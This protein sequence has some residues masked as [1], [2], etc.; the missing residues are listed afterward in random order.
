[1]SVV[2]LVIFLVS[3]G[4]DAHGT[5]R[6][7]L[8]GD[9]VKYRLPSHLKH[10][11][12]DSFWAGLPANESQCWRDMELVQKQA[13]GL[14]MWALKMLDASAKLPSGIISGNL[15]QFGDFDEC[16]SVLGGNQGQKIKGKYCLAN[17]HIKIN[18]ENAEE[19]KIQALDDAIHSHRM[20][21]NNIFDEGHRIPKFETFVWG[22]CVPSSCSSRDIEAALGYKLKKISK[23]SPLSFQMSIND[24]MCYVKEEKQMTVAKLL[25]TKN[26]S[27]LT[28]TKSSEDDIDCLNGARFLNAIAL[29][30]S[31]KQI[32]MFY[33]PTHNRTSMA[34]AFSKSWTMLGRSAILY[35]DSFIMISGILASYS[36]VKSLDRKRT[37][38]FKDKLINRLVRF[39]PNL[40][41]TL[42]F[43]TYLMED[44]NSGPHWGLVINKYADLCKKNM[45]RNLL[46]I[47]NYFGFE[48]MC[49][50][51]THQLGIDMQLFLVSPILVYILWKSPRFGTVL[52][53]LISSASTWLRYNVTLTE[54]LSTN[55]YYGISV[56]QLWK[57]ANLSY[58]LPTHRLTVYVAGLMIGYYLRRNG[59]K[60]SYNRVVATVGWI[61]AVVV[62]LFAVF[63]PYKSA[64]KG[65]VYD[66]IYAAQFNAFAPILWTIFIAWVLLACVNGYGGFFNA[67]LSWKYFRIFSKISYGI[68]LTQFPVFFYGIGTER[69]TQ[70]YKGFHAIFDIEE[71]LIII[72]AAII[73][74]LL[75][76]MPSQELKKVLFKSNKAKNDTTASAGVSIQNVKDHKTRR[77]LYVYGT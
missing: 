28:S 39:T 38:N 42:L 25:V 41:G 58:I 54:N 11:L 55:I 19:P 73:L 13:V 53:F 52:L 57:T 68:Y 3:L 46:Y 15:N 59:S 24:E 23:G 30:L 64:Y 7:F 4:L 75:F 10:Y 16:I 29:L 21:T 48:N 35:T 44:M 60:L 22:V 49:L 63:G 45:W 69:T 76:D 50:T 2:L 20:L 40:L 43:F 72:I 66:P 17:I 14:N 1:M 27:L 47:H 26:W 56:E 33:T 37:I 18:N 36:F 9:A 8:E 31:H 62:A 6:K 77:R 65:Y 34:E 67:F 74:T 5:E 12:T 70:F 51:H 61:V 32:A 71:F